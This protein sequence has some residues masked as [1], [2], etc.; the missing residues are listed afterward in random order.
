[1]AKVSHLSRD[2]IKGLAG[3]LDFYYWK[4]QPVCRQWPRYPR[5]PNSPAQ[6]ATRV[7][8]VASRADLKQISAE[9]RALWPRDFFGSRQS[10]L[11]Y[12]TA[13]YLMYLKLYGVA[14]PVLTGI[15]EV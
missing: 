6:L 14:P 2:V 8:L 13:M 11:D 5:Q 15:T 1:M 12:Y 9:V 7:A 10:W 4:G 3:Q